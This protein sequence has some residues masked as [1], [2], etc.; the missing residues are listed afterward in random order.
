MG[1]YRL[2]ARLGAGGM[3]VVYLGESRSGRRVAVKVIRPRIAEDPGFRRRFRREVEAAR[4]VG[5]FWTAPVVDA[6]PEAETPWVASD[7]I[8]APDLLEL[9]EERGPFAE[10]EL[11]RLG[12]GM[13]E[14]LHSVHRAGLVHRDLKPAN[15]LVTDNGPRLIDFGIAKALDGGTAI[16]DTG[17]TIGT[18][19]FMSPEQASGEAVGTPSDIF[20]L[21]AVL[22]F[23]ATGRKP[24]GDGVGAAVLFR[25]VHERP[26]TDGM[27][28]GLLPLVERFME[29]D[30]A[31]RPDADEALTLLSEAGP[32]VPAA[33]RVPGTRKGG[34]RDEDASGTAGGGAGS[35]RA[36]ADG[37][38]S[39]GVVGAEAD[40]PTS[41]GVAGAVA[42][43]TTG[44]SGVAGPTEE[45]TPARTREERPA[46]VPDAAVGRADAPTRPAPLRSADGPLATTPPPVAP[47]AP[48]SRPAARPSG[49]RMPV[50]PP[51]S[52]PR[53]VPGADAARAVRPP[54]P[55]RPAGPAAE[56]T[57]V[58]G[59]GRVAYG[60]AAAGVVPAVG[61]VMLFAG[62]PIVAGVLALAATAC[63]ALAFVALGRP[64]R[65]RF[66][67][68]RT[69]IAFLREGH[70]WSA[71][72]D[73]LTSV[74]LRWGRWDSVQELIVVA[75]VRPGLG[76]V[77]WEKFRTDRFGPHVAVL[78]VRFTDSALASGEALRLHGA[79][80]DGPAGVYR[81]DPEVLL[82]ARGR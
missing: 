72:W 43:G 25:V 17:M 41:A 21:G 36:E 65:G 59:H 20:S 13:A 70:E 77:V 73:E 80:T 39:A 81:P 35:R 48:A 55:R 27:P 62:S 11:L 71:R 28:G 56:V 19:G 78:P 7:Y 18:A 49:A 54:V 37:T 53:A 58:L 63:F 76:N 3:G 42:D 9:V 24:F 74:T 26:D 68:D 79:L 22:C 6:E 52:P 44:S 66:R 32:V 50:T 16:T 64:D 40:G 75:E 61:A 60:A 10:P 45:A 38:T 46:A 8:P 34:S 30:P 1:P 31:R 14:A 57:F 12:A 5:G 51:P 33:P 23:A 4:T 82:R 15:V 69:G 67:V 2:T 47:P 29:K